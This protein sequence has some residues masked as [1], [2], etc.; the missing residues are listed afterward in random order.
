MT[1]SLIAAIGNNNELGKNN[2][3]LWNL[4]A[5]M[6]HFRDTTRGHTVI[7]G[8]KTH[9]SIGRPLPNRRNIVITR[10]TTYQKDGVEVVHSIDEALK[11]FEN[12][13]E[14]VFCIGG[15]DVYAQA[16]PYANK[17]YITHLDATFDADTFFPRIDEQWQKHSETIRSADGENPYTLTFTE[18]IK[19]EP[20]A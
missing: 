6:K 17:L 9:E 13:D 18:Y 10:D 2:Q 14:E 11:L 8:R 4:P 20:A 12:T 3:L 15:A 5:D 1:L 19:K 16:L 7:M